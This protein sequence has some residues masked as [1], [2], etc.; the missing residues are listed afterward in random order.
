MTRSDRNDSTSCAYQFLFLKFSFDSFFIAPH[1][2]QSL[3][4]SN[5]VLF[6]LKNLRRFLCEKGQKPKNS[7]LKI[8]QVFCRKPNRPVVDTNFSSHLVCTWYVTFCRSAA[9]EKLQKNPLRER[10]IL[11]LHLHKCSNSYVFFF[12]G[13]IKPNQAK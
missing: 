10:E 2:V 5:Y 11:S 7:M 8:R 3:F 4:G 1:C 12:Q 9:R 13:E 6:S